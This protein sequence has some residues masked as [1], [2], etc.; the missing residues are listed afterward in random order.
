MELVLVPDRAHVMHRIWEQLVTFPSVRT[1][2]LI[3][4]DAAITNATAAF[5][6]KATRDQ[7]A[8]K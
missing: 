5:V 3:P 8:G 6:K 2:A 1:T 4:T 7:T